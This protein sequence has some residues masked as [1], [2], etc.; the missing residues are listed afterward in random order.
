MSSFFPD[1]NCFCIWKTSLERYTREERVT[2]LATEAEN[3]YLRVR[4][5]RKTAHLHVFIPSFPLSELV[6][7]PVDH[8]LKSC[9][10]HPRL[11]SQHCGG[12]SRKVAWTDE[13]KT[14]LDS[15]ET[16]QFKQQNAKRFSNEKESVL[17]KCFGHFENHRS[18]K[19]INWITIMGI[20]F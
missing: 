3:R 14:S 18:F 15:I 11:Q 20:C 8:L 19:K 4:G 13:F 1:P 6:A 17:R 5:G 10:P 16:S 2:L 12:W 9:E 7:I